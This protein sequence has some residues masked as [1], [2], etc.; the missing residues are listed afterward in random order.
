MDSFEFESGRT[1]EDVN[2]EYVTSGIPKYDDEGNIVNAIVY[3]PTLNGGHAILPQYHR[4][5]QKNNFKK[6]EYFFIRIYSLGTTGSCSPSGTG[7]K[8]DFPS[9]TFKDR[10]DF[11]R[12]FLSEKFN[13]K[14]IFGII[15]EGIGG[16]EVFTWACE[17]PDEMEF[18]I[19]LNSIYKLYG[20]CYVVTKSI[21]SM[22]DASDDFYSDNYSSSLSRLSVSLLRL[23]FMSYFPDKIFKS[24]SNDEIDVLMEDYVDNGL[25]MDIYDFKFRNDSILR[26]DVEDGLSNIKAKSLFIGTTG[27]MFYYPENDL[28]P[29]GDMVEDSK[30]CLF[31]SGRKNYYEE[32][33]N[34]DI[35]NEIISFLKQFRK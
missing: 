18:I 20:N 4:Y 6:N 34:S 17:Y 21:E 27:Y 31:E 10:V 13:I 7:L 26:Y 22:I 3:C 29:L 32:A 19:L 9:Y 14:K 11:K 23:L 35:I 16:F 24:L 2:V 12:Q 30:V 28:I 5:F 1:L 15:G 8:Y 25:F 33:D